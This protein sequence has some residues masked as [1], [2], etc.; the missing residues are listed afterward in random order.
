LEQEV[1]VSRPPDF[2]FLQA[3]DIY[4]V[5]TASC[6]QWLADSKEDGRAAQ[7]DLSWILGFISA[8]NSASPPRSMKHVDAAGMRSFIDQ[9]CDAHRLG[10]IVEAAV[11]LTKE[12]RV[13]TP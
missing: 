7:Y 9:Y 10:Q 2:L 8:I 3:D 5:G 13:K 11:A 12:R 1:G 4:G 6:G